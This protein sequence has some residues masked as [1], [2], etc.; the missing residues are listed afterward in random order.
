MM[1]AGTGNPGGPP[2]GT[3]HADA[4]RFD[5]YEARRRRRRRRAMFLL[6][7]GALLAGA[8]MVIA[9]SPLTR[10]LIVPRV[11][12]ML[13]VT[14]EGG[15]ASIGVDGVVTVRNAVV[16]AP[17]VPGT[18]GAV[19]EVSRLNVR[20]TWS[21]LLGWGGAGSPA[22]RDV[23]LVE[24][25]VRLSQSVE[26]GAMNF[27]SLDL[28]GPAGGTGALPRITVRRGVIE[29]GEHWTDASGQARYTPL[30]RLD[31]DGEVSPSKDLEKGVYRIA[32]QQIDRRDAPPR[33]D[34]PR[35]RLLGIEGTVSERGVSITMSDLS[36]G[37]FAPSS[38][39][40]RL[41]PLFE[42]LD[43]AGSV[44]RTRLEFDAR[45]GPR[46]ELELDRVAVN[47]PI[48]AAEEPIEGPTMPSP[49]ARMREVSG[50]VKF[51]RG[52]VEAE[53]NG[54]LED[55]P[56]RVRLKYL[57]LT[58]DASFECDLVC[59]NFRMEEKPQV[60]RFAPP[61]VRYRLAQFSNPTGLVT[62]R[63]YVRRGKPENGRASEV[64][65]NGTL[66]F[67]DVTAAYAAFPYRF[68]G[69]KGF[70]RFD[71]RSVEIVSLEGGAPGGG[72]ISATARIAP[73]TDAAA[74]HIEVQVRDIPIDE[75]LEEAMGPRSKLV[76]EIASA[77]Q[78]RRLAERGAFLT[79]EREQLLRDRLSEARLREAAAESEPVRAGARREAEAIEQS[80]RAP[81]FAFR[82]KGDVS[83]VVDRLEGL[84]SI[85]SQIIDVK[86]G[87]V[88]LLPDR[89]PL[90]I[91]SEGVR[92]V[93]DGET[94]QVQDG[95][96]R[97][98]NGGDAT[99]R[100]SMIYPTL[101]NP[102]LDPMP[103]A[104]I[105]ATGVPVDALVTHAVAGAIDRATSEAGEGAESESAAFVR[106][107]LAGLRLS[108]RMDATANLES[109]E[110]G[111]HIA[112]E[113]RSADLVARPQ[114]A[115]AVA[116][117][118]AAEASVRVSDSLVEV[119]AKGAVVG[120]AGEAD[121]GT[122]T[123]GA[124]VNI[125]RSGPSGWSAEI[126]A[127]GLD[128][129]R[130]VEAMVGVF[131]EAAADRIE[132]VRTT[133]DPIGR[134][135]VAATLSGGAPGLA[136]EVRVTEFD[137]AT[138]NALG[139]RTTL[140]GSSG[141]VV[142]R[143]FVEGREDTVI[144]EKFSAGAAC[145]GAPAGAI[146]LD[147]EVSGIGTPEMGGR[148]AFGVEGARFE[149]PFVRRLAREHAGPGLA[150]LVERS[151]PEGGFD[152]EMLFA[153]GGDGF[154]LTRGTVRP[155]SLALML[156]S[157]KA[158]W[159]EMTGRIEFRPE[160]GTFHDLRGTG[161][162]EA[163]GAGAAWSFGAEGSW[164]I[165]APGAVAV[166][167]DVSLES[168]GLPRGL[169]AVL[170]VELTEAID[171]LSF[172]SRG[173]I[174]VPKATVTYNDDGTSEGRRVRVVGGVEFDGVSLDAG[175]PVTECDGAMDFEVQRESGRPASYDL[176]GLLS[177]LRFAGLAMTDGRLRL[178]GGGE[179]DDVLVPEVSADC[180]GGRAMGRMSLRP[181]SDGTRRYDANIKLSGVRF[182]PVLR[183]LGARPPDTADAPGAEPDA[184][185][186]DESRGRLDANLS[187]G[188]VLGDN[189]TR[190]GRGSGMVGGGSVIE[191]PLLLPLIKFS[192]LQLPIDE[193]LQL[194]TGSFYIQ[195]DT[196]VFEDVSAFSSSV[197][198]FGYGTAT[199]PGLDLNLRFNSRAVRR[200]PVISGLIESIRDEIVSTS[201]TGNIRSPEISTSPLSSTSRMLEALFGTPSQQDRLMEEIERRAIR[202]LDRARTGGGRSG[203]EPARAGG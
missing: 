184:G 193:R 87:T 64:R 75:R 119:A 169:R 100:A 106:E 174:R 98:L 134:A 57:G 23:E 122:V 55:L 76:R 102:D 149:H 141:A 165:P 13:N 104:R 48:D 54:L 116:E 168:R 17:G 173:A 194:A 170:P 120:A 90:P 110:E 164:V 160:S 187:L 124:S 30:S 18:A 53:L 67:N 178:S 74:A 111:T 21:R 3:A 197:R 172:E 70:V 198:I 91:V 182:A 12:A 158:E 179:S 68:H 44:R 150:E 79:P 24:P 25:L 140:T 183:D 72:R 101:E 83:I 147:G 129:T 45:E 163:P 135:S 123:L 117:V 114:R 126:D 188:G 9:H 185:A 131:S 60:L 159:P 203:S 7:V 181:E 145:D 156:P 109:D 31:V 59:E 50:T 84:E 65:V 157:G 154:E 11:E 29:L 161:R 151:A 19:F 99:V 192:N 125:S 143:P 94:V 130:P 61:R 180:Y 132:R 15:A 118:R 37:D 195:G 35:P 2:R 108:G 97:G 201:V 10:R 1:Q 16:R 28:P 191:L 202:D 113:A 39:P 162:E 22:V 46:A 136:G 96:Y 144:F 69:I 51:L 115:G 107:M 5:R 36:L 41:R 105:E 85:W 166:Q 58:E 171:E 196:V 34:V 71:D 47:L 93:I 88:G 146:S 152:A 167:A 137:G 153:S 32:V 200:L 177:R 33:E 78:H 56:Y 133:A 52:G 81:V 148:L 175:A 189:S 66:E 128:V 43:L 190:R 63:A 38:I 139:T 186:L 26:S 89:F 112:A 20:P 127:R 82:G 8:W 77:D 27:A 95:T 142:L 4:E 80:L 6:F 49:P 176:W 40:T 86:L 121:A 155:C 138:L 103:R 14:V 199:W 42:T 73:L 92:V 62:A